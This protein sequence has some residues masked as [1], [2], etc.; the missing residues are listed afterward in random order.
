MRG[1]IPPLPQ[2]ALM[3]WC[4]VKSTE[5]TLPLPYI[6]ANASVNAARNYKRII[7]QFIDPFLNII[8]TRCSLLGLSAALGLS[9]S[10]A[11][12]APRL[13]ISTSNDKTSTF[14]VVTM[15]VIFT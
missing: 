7:T 14:P 15:F 5:T 3:A 11:A 13:I 12:K 10:L 6:P 1:A 8:S 2:Y 4:S 9:S